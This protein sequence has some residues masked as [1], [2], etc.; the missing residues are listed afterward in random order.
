MPPRLCSLSFHFLTATGCCTKGGHDLQYTVMCIRLTAYLSLRDPPGAMGERELF[1]LL[2]LPGI[3]SALF[4]LNPSK[5]KGL[6][7]LQPIHFFRAKDDLA[8]QNFIEVEASY[9]YSLSPYALLQVPFQIHVWPVEPGFD[10]FPLEDFRRTCLSHLPGMP[11]LQLAAV[12][13]ISEDQRIYCPH[14]DCS[15]LLVL[16]APPDGSPAEC[17][18]CHRMVCPKCVTAQ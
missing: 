4:C 18:E 6:K 2:P 7:P 16:D 12:A 5:K 8:S 3:S 17:P 13:S 15:A 1:N 11:Y 14:P 10:A 9:S